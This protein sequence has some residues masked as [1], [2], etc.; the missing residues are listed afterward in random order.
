MGGFAAERLLPG[1]GHHIE[2]AP[3][4]RLREGGGG[5]V[6]NGQAGPVGGDPVGIG[7]AHARGRAVPGEHHV[8]CRI[9]LAQVGQFAVGGFERDDVLEL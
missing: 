3:F 4:Q 5:R 6:A 1:E 2:L 7:D 9:D 8:A